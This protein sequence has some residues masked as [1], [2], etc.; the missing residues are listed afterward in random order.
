MNAQVTAS[1]SVRDGRKWKTTK[2]MAG[3]IQEAVGRE[4]VGRAVVVEAHVYVVFFVRRRHAPAHRQRRPA[5]Q[6]ARR[7]A[8]PH[9]YIRV[10][11]NRVAPRRPRVLLLLLFCLSAAASRPHGVCRRVGGGRG[12]GLTALRVARQSAAHETLDVALRQHERRGLLLLRG[13]L[14]PTRR[15]RRPPARR[16]ALTRRSSAGASSGPRRRSCLRAGTS[17]TGTQ[18]V[19]DRIIGRTS[20]AAR[21]SRHRWR[22]GGL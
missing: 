14:A 20:R 19:R 21:C 4:I 6:W 10:A 16:P 3:G 13:T 1:D 7:V 11:L 18:R 2:S 5:L 8:A 17:E 22:A 12:D 9:G 15:R